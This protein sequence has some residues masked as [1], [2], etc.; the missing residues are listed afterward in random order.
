MSK[1]G[2]I[3]NT[4]TTGVLVGA[5]AYYI[6]ARYFHLGPIATW[7]LVWF[8]GQFAA[9]MY[10]TVSD[11][12]NCSKCRRKCD[13]IVYNGCAHYNFCLHCDTRTYFKNH[14]GEWRDDRSGWL[15]SCTRSRQCTRCSV[16]EYAEHEGAWNLIGTS[17][18]CSERTCTHCG[19]FEQDEH[20]FAFRWPEKDAEVRGCARCHYHSYSHHSPP[21]EE[22][23]L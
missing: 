3:F 22:K 7:I 17:D 18:Q 1:A 13:P 16:V 8:C 4:L 20:K 2:R 19:Y 15:K 5:I 10:Y 9:Q 6:C 11:W 21:P 14:V 12:E 23:W